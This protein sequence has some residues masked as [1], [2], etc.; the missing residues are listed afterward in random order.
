M[1]KYEISCFSEGNKSDHAENS[2]TTYDVDDVNAIVANAFREEAG[3][4]MIII[5]KSPE[6]EIIDM[7]K[8]MTTVQ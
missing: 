2:Y 8:P 7:A 5:H 4:G 6:A 3:I 1:R